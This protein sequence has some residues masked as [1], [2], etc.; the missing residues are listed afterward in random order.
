V[1]SNDNITSGAKVL[2]VGLGADEQM[3]GYGRHRSVY[4]RGGYEALRSELN[5]EMQRLWYRNLGRDDRCISDHGKEARFPF[6]DE[7]VVNFL[8]SIELNSICDMDRQQG[9]GDKMILRLI[10]KMIG[11]KECSHLVKRAIQF[12]SRIAKVSE[13]SCFVS[14]RQASGTANF[15]HG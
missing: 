4:Q 10:A 5:M 14:R 8:S 9:I 13:A 7:D 12:G 2:I 3:A 6:L 1:S 11:V 15:I